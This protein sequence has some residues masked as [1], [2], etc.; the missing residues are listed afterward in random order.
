MPWIPTSIY[1][2]I[3]SSRWCLLQLIVVTDC[4]SLFVQLV[5]EKTVVDDSMY[6]GNASAEGGGDDADNEV[7]KSGCS[8]VLANR[9]QEQEK[10]DKAAFKVDIKVC[11]TWL[12]CVSDH[13]LVHIYFSMCGSEAG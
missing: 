3:L 1:V 12:L 4:V 9:L 6:G 2:C 5:S 13:P 10:Y 8:I 11:C 7:T